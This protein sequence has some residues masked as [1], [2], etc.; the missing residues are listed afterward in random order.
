MV[1]QKQ[2]WMV[3][4]ALLLSALKEAKAHGGLIGVHSENEAITEYNTAKALAEGNTSA[5]Y[6][7]ITKPNL[8]ELEAIGRAILLAKSSGAALY[9]FHM[10][11][12]EGVE[13][14]RANRKE[15]YPI[16]AETCSRYLGLTSDKLKGPNGINFICSP[17]LREQADIDALWQGI[18]DGSIST[19]ASDH[20]AL[21]AENKSTWSES[22]ATVPNGFEGVEYL[23]PVVFSEGVSK[24]RIDLSKLVAV[25]CTNPAKIFGL[26]P[27]KGVI[28]VGSDADIVVVDPGLEKVLSEKSS[29]LKLGWCPFEGFKVKFIRLR[30]SR[31]G[32]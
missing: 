8:V 2:G 26:Y 21:S 24:G 25:L 17:P 31:K 5:I 9:D 12:K 11:I 19:I 14:V 3:D 32:M 16:Y 10:S 1:Y 30:L 27:K 4:D 23:L 22:F 18:N 6:H 15:G 28:A 20:C 13:A 29:Y 7:S